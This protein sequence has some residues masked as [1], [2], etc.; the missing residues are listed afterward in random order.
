MAGSYW[1]LSPSDFPKGEPVLKMKR[2]LWYRPNNAG[3]TDS[4]LRAGYY[5]RDEAL[6]YCFSSDG[7]NGSCDVL[8]VPLRMAL[9]QCELS[10]PGVLEDVADRVEILRRLRDGESLRGA[11][12]ERNLCCPFCL[13]TRPPIVKPA[14]ELFKARLGCRDCLEWWDV[15]RLHEHKK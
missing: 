6:E 5:D 7:K 11:T 2:G 13:S 8:A 9:E 14:D 4:L 12:P 10:D 1:N 3:Y 15:P